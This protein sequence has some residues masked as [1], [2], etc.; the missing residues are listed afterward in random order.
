ML[1]YKNKSKLIAHRTCDHP[2]LLRHGGGGGDGGVAA[3]GAEAGLAADEVLR[4][5]RARDHAPPRRGTLPGRRHRE[6]L[7]KRP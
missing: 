3:A 6:S 7:H 4:G 1:E 5:P 2:G